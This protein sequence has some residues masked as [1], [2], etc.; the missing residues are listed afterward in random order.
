MGLTSSLSGGASFFDSTISLRAVG[1][2]LLR[3]LSYLSLGVQAQMPLPSAGIEK[4]LAVWSK[5]GVWLQNSSS[6]LSF[7]I[8]CHLLASSFGLINPAVFRSSQCPE[9]KRVHGRFWAMRAS[10]HRVS[11]TYAG[12]CKLTPR[13]CALGDHHGSTWQKHEKN[14]ETREAIAGFGGFGGFWEVP[15]LCD[16]VS[17]TVQLA[18]TICCKRWGAVNLICQ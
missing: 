12:R 4:G 15:R 9:I 5:P 16:F 2:D 1:K 13:P 18:A 6:T 17:R 8:C 11:A 14:I 10:L 3:D 7:L